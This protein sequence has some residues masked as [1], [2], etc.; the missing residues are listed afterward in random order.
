MTEELYEE[1]EAILIQADLGVEASVGLVE[2]LR[3][4]AKAEKI[5]AAEELRWLLKDELKKLIGEPG[6]LI[7]NPSG[8]TVV[9]IVGVNG[10]GKTTS[11]GKLAYHLAEQGQK[12]VLGAADTFRAAAIEQLEIWGERAGAAVIRHQ[13]GSD[14]AAVAFDAVQAG[15]SR[16]A[17]YILIDTAGR[18]HTQTNLMQELEKV[19]RVI[20]RAMD[21]APHEILLVVD[22]T[23]GQNALNQAK[24]FAKAVPITGI[25][26]TKLDGTA[27][28]G[29]VAA[30]VNTLRVPVKF[31]GIGEGVE[32]LK[33]FDTEAFVEAIFDRS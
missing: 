9:M 19:G 3:Q 13:M 27:K 30:V 10:T 2:T 32:D 26:L 17:D 23:T 28:G 24:L 16:R 25:I 14:P 18:L 21:G 6:V 29:I 20:G 5:K 22:A 31:I 15:L 7:E 8:P 11:V 33:P 1:L 12:V 4:R